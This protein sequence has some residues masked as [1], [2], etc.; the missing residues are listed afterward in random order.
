MVAPEVKS[1]FWSSASP[2]LGKAL[3][4]IVE[5]GCWSPSHH[6]FIPGS[7]MKEWMKKKGPRAHSSILI[8][9]FFMKTH[10]MHFYLLVWPSHV[11]AKEG[12][13]S[14]FDGQVLSKTGGSNSKE[15][16]WTDTVAK[17]WSLPWFCIKI[18]LITFPRQWLLT[19]LDYLEKDLP[20]LSKIFFHFAKSCRDLSPLHE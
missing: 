16:G 4:L 20:L 13:N 15:W 7:R 18:K 10:S 1:S 11:A 8:K 14:V 3:V 12:G 19:V 5:Y 6:L 17:Y 9:L 2:L